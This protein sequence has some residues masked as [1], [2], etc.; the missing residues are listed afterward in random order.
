[1]C[2]EAACLGHPATYSA[3]HR[4][5]QS[6]VSNLGRSACLYCDGPCFGNDQPNEADPLKGD[7]N[8]IG[9]ASSSH[10]ANASFIWKE[11]LEC[12]ATS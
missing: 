2:G 1:V 7:S 6:E 10:Q 8:Y 5:I 4:R 3:V 9:Y 12:L 11:C